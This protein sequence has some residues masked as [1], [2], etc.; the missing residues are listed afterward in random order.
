MSKEALAK[1]VQR[2]IS[3]ASF[4]RQLSSDPAGALRG[5]DLTA[6]EMSAVRTAD[7]GR[8]SAL[9]IDQ[10][11]SKAFTLGA[12]VVA[13][14]MAGT[15]LSMQGTTMTAGGAS[16][17]TVIPYDPAGTLPASDTVDANASTTADTSVGTGSVR[18]VIPYDPAGTLPDEDSLA[19]RSDTAARTGDDWKFTDRG[20][21]ADTAAGSGDDLRER[22]PIYDSGS[23]EAAVASDATGMENYPE[24]YG[25]A[26]PSS[27]ESTRA[28][29]DWARA[30][31]ASVDEAARAGDD[32]AR[33]S[34]AS[35]DEAAR[36][37]T[38]RLDDA[39]GVQTTDAFIDESSEGYL[40]TP[41]ESDA[42]QIKITTGDETWSGDD[43]A[44]PT[45]V[46]GTTDSGGDTPAEG[47]DT[48]V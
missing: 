32:W 34:S 18:T 24:H 36:A 9:G 13:T 10:R 11:V 46:E 23:P 4:R 26:G 43:I 12:S 28:G 14:R 3:D 42:D 16:G 25:L 2:A 19:A 37:G 6:D 33:A 30:G 29:D 27:L 40:T 39:S 41:F 31:S 5:F 48:P 45:T 1:V 17:Q 22:S 7:S 8:L 15:D 38:A 21:A 35:L 44:G 20:V 47:P